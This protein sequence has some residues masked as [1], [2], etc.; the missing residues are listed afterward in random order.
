MGSSLWFK[1][2]KSGGLNSLAMR[3]VNHTYPVK[4]TEYSSFRF[5]P[6][7]RY[8]KELETKEEQLGWAKCVETY[9][10]IRGFT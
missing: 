1:T 8:V 10:F 4:F 7:V 5:F 6:L 9:T 3:F 2:R